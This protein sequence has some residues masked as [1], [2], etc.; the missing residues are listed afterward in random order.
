MRISTSQHGGIVEVVA[1]GRLDESWADH[2]GSA[3]D[4]V[5]RDGTHHVRLNM[6]A[7][8]YLSSAGIRILVRCYQDLKDINGSFAITNPSR[9]VRNIL[10]MTRLSPILISEESSAAAAPPPAEQDLSIKTENGSFQVLEKSAG[11]TLTCQ[12]F[13]DGTRLEGGGYST[14]DMSAVRYPN[15]TFGLGVGAFGSDFSDCRDRFGEFLAAGAAAAYLPTDGAS[16]P[17]YLIASGSLVPEVGVLYGIRCEGNFALHLRF[18][19]DKETRDIGLA[20]I[21]SACLKVAE[22]DTAGIVMIA[23]STGLVGAALRRSPASERSSTGSPFAHPDIRKWVTFT[24]EPAH[25][26][27]LCLVAGIAST[28]GAAAADL[29]SLLRALPHPSQSLSGH[30]HSAVFPYRPI[31]KGKL[32]LDA[33]VKLLFEG[34]GPHGL[35]HLLSDN[36]EA[37]G[38][39]ESKFVRGACWVAPIREVTQKAT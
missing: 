32:E 34:H 9:Q 14:E 21:V 19:A 11:H 12:I 17:D 3:L 24:A 16:V 28:D 22:A 20:E 36:R 31:Q 23:E 39:G 27:S 38:A 18:Q 2:L 25:A 13:G 37:A 30:F 10:D 15:G 26:G 7:V 8:S 1:A 35:L 33:M 29:G 5:V 4:E 6:E